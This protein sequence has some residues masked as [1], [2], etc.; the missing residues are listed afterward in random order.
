MLRNY[1]KVAFRN[2]G[3]EKFYAAVNILG[4][5]ISIACCLVI[6]VYLQDELSYDRFPERA[7]RIYRVAGEINFGGNH[8]FYA[9]TPAPMAGALVSDYPEV[10]SSFRF[11][12]WGNWL[13]RPEQTTVNTKEDHVAYAD[14][15][16]FQ[17]FSVPVLSGD[18]AQALR[19]PDAVAISASAAKRHFGSDDPVGQT[20]VFDD[21]YRYRVGAVFEDI[22]KNA[23]FHFDFLLAMSGY[24]DSR[25]P[26]WL[27]NNYHTYITLKEGA[28][29]AAFEAKFP[30]LFRK[31]AGPQVQQL[32]DKSI[33]E[34]E[35]T[36]QGVHYTLQPLRDIH[37]RSDLTAEL[38]PNSDIKYVYIFG[39]IALFILLIACINFMN[40][41]TARSSNRAKEVGVRKTLGAI[42]QDLIGQFLTESILMSVLSFIL[43]VLIAEIGVRY[44]GALVGKTLNLPLSDP[45]FLAGLAGAALL[46]GLLAGAYP[47]FYLSSFMPVD[48]LKG[49]LRA[50]MRGGIFRNGLVVFQFVI[51]IFL[52]IG[53]LIINEQLN[54]IRNKKLGFERE[55]VLLLHDAYALGNQ[56][57]TFKEQ[58]EQLPGVRSASFSSYLPVRSSRSDNTM[59]PEG[60]MTETNSV[61][62]QMWQVD[63][64]Y[65]STLGMQLVAGRNFS[66]E[67]PTDSNAVILNQRAVDL[68]GFDDPIGKR[69]SAFTGP[70]NDLNN[71][72]TYH[73]IGVVENF[74]Y[75][76]LR[77]N[78]DA[79]GLFLNPSSG[80]LALRYQS[81]DPSALISQ[82]EAQWR[83]MAPGQPFAYSFLDERFEAMYEAEQR[84]SGIFLL[85]AGLAIFVACLGLFALATFTAERR[86]KEIGVRKVMGASSF[87]IF[88]LLSSEFTRWVALAYLI[89]LPLGWYFARQ[90]LRDF[91]YQTSIS[92]WI[93]AAAALIALL[94]ALVTVSYQ[95]LRAAFS[96][97]VEALR[98]E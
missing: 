81:D 82:V 4:L 5:A 87:D 42:K 55:Q 36:G 7:D 3:R 79:L 41:A 67:M 92:F 28:D 49:K 57:Q 98:Y 50:G 64:D 43:A 62:T 48:T 73:V 51:S 95:A 84:T 17:F 93:F 32:L 25:S 2:I 70:S 52:I 1:L 45:L 68:Y 38:E 11:R 21:E 8:T 16:F 53:T 46:I 15:N 37:L 65:V 31:Y 26:I 80:Y 75:E 24:E 9:V 88:T 13:V 94:I 22:P 12:Q 90:W 71:I 78:I 58:M 83:T 6:L 76:S 27:S 44:F 59:W 72:T 47:S 74:H 29:P 91:E 56:R 86:T 77:E 18:A 54:F 85:F 33:E 89:A 61:S 30:S 63:E 34:I 19:A 96:N 10:E 97:P 66:R 39:S 40:L 35:A 23:H 14:S 20:L 60:K 69:I